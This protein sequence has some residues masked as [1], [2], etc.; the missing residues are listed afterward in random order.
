[1]TTTKQIQKAFGRDNQSYADE[2]EA[3][4]ADVER[5]LDMVGRV[6]PRLERAIRINYD[7]ALTGR[8]L[9]ALRDLNGFLH[10]LNIGLTGAIADAFEA[11][12]MFGR[13]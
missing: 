12:D 2:I 8:M 3:T 10:G 9:P 4:R 6:S 7:N 13:D 1:M 5:K 11:C